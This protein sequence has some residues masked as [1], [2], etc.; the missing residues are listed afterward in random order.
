MSSSPTAKRAVNSWS[1]ANQ[2]GAERHRQIEVEQRKRQPAEHDRAEQRERR[3]LQQRDQ[4][5]L[6]HD[7]RRDDLTDLR[8]QGGAADQN[9]TPG[10]RPRR[11]PQFR[12]LTPDQP[13][14]DRRD[15]QGIAIRR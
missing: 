4:G 6:L 7:Q 12:T 10:P 8:D 11:D 5:E 1:G 14:H 15:Q 2:A 9:E 3:G 13:S